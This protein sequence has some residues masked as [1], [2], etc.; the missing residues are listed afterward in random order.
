MAIAEVAKS[1]AISA[2]LE[3]C[4]NELFLGFAEEMKTRASVDS[5]KKKP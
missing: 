3:R 2:L 1:G 4:S 5:L